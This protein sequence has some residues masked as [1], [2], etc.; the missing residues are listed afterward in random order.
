[1][2]TIKHDERG[3]L[4]PI[5]RAVKEYAKGN[6]YSVCSCCW[7]YPNPTYKYQLCDRC[8]PVSCYGYETKVQKQY[9]LKFR[10][11]HNNEI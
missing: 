10:K 5:V 4:F 3:L 1:M 7:N 11:E 6:G 9:C 2:M 8:L